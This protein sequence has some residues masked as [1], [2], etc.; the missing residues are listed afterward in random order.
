MIDI[1]PPHHAATTWRD[2][3]IHIATIVL[4][5][6]IAIG[7]E[8]TVELVHRHREE[9]EA[10]ANIREE[11]ATNIDITQRDLKQL[12]L[13]RQ[14]LAGDYDVLNGGVGDAQTLAQ[15]DYNLDFTRRH[16]AAWEAAKIN[17]SLA[18]IPSREIGHTSYYYA[19]AAALEPSVQAFFTELDTAQVLVD[20]A[21]VAGK[22]TAF[23]RQQLVS[24]STSAMGHAKFLSR[25]FSYES[26]AIER[27]SLQ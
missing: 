26:K 16:D 23:D 8:Q 2:F 1:H 17:G 13:I 4:G 12:S 5:L 22:L 20:H 6:L 14:K 18:L 25:M 9:R 24:L 15:L 11:I 3:F 19:T 21:K 27:N 10:R 7:L